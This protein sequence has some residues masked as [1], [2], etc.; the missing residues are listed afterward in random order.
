MEPDYLFKTKPNYFFMFFMVAGAVFFVFMANLLCPL[1]KLGELPKEDKT[2]FWV[3]VTVMF[4]FF[5]FSVMCLVLALA[6]KVIYLTQNE[7][8]VSTPLFFYKR[9]I[10]LN[11]IKGMTEKEEKIS[12]SNNL[13]YDDRTTIGHNTTLQLTD[14]R[15]A[16]ISSIQVWGYNELIK[17]IHTQIRVN[18]S[19]THHH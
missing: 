2:S 18:N 8:I 12:A 3:H 10:M 4:I 5:G 9:T 13:F 6:F 1:S 7:V 17:K 11:E 15:K 16:G 19:N 14:G